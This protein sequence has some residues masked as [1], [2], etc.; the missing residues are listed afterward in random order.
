MQPFTHPDSVAK[1]THLVN[2]ESLRPLEE[3][4]ARKVSIRAIW[5]P[6]GRF[7]AEVFAGLWGGVDYDDEVIETYSSSYGGRRP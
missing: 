4:I 2:A 6:K 3:A 7:V 5:N 1:S